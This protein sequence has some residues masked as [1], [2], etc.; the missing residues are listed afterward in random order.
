MT[1]ANAYGLVRA[2]IADRVSSGD[3]VT[4]IQRWAQEQDF[5]LFDVA[6][7]ASPVAFQ[8]FLVSLRPCGISAVVVPGLWHVDG[9]RAAINTEADLWTLHPLHRWPRRLPPPSP[10]YRT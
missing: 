4:E 6:T 5:A 7:V 1:Y 10:S 2:D 3:R 9:W 8:L